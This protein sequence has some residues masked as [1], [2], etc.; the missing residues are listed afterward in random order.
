MKRNNSEPVEKEQLSFSASKQA[1]KAKSK[2]AL[3]G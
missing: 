3:T 1:A 2:N